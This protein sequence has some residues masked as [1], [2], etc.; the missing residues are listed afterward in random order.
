MSWPVMKNLRT[1]KGS[2]TEILR[3]S[4]G[5]R[6]ASLV[7][8]GPFE[9]VKLFKRCPSKLNFKYLS[10]EGSACIKLLT[11]PLPPTV[12]T[13]LNPSINLPLQPTPN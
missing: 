3:S 9:K 4:A 2:S 13:T 8:R 1:Y 7:P 10:S 12:S 11:L 6:I 5:D